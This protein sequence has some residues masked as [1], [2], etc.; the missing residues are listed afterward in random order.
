MKRI[1]QPEL[2]DALP[3]DDPRAIW[4]RRDLR[5]I[6][7]WMRNPSIMATALKNQL[8]GCSG[9]RETAASFPRVESSGSLPRAATPVLHITDLGA[10]DGHFLVRVAEKISPR[11]PGANVTLLDNQKVTDAQTLAFFESFGWRAEAI[12]ADV[13][14]WANRR[15]RRLSAAR[16]SAPARR[17]P[18]GESPGRQ[19]AGAPGVVVA[20]LFLHHFEDARLAELFRAVAGRARLFAAIEP[21]RAPWPLFCCRLRW[22]IGCNS[23]TRHDAAISVRAGFSGR[24]LSALWPA[25]SGWQCTERRAGVFSHLFVARKIS[26]LECADMSALSTAV[27]PRRD[28]RT[29]K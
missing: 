19:D 17:R 12:K 23:V 26:G 14:D 24:E 25:D 4:S 28:R 29:P 8:N 1:V 27:P 7:A 18:A 13:F 3:P 20:N 2:L 22:A 5:R 9:G 6:N 10:G 15:E 21:R 16:Q 11:W